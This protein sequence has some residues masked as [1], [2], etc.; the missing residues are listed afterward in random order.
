MNKKTNPAPDGNESQPL[1][2]TEKKPVKRKS[3]KSDDTKAAASKSSAEKASTPK[4]KPAAKKTAKASAKTAPKSAAKVSLVQRIKN[5]IKQGLWW[6]LKTTAKLTL[7][8]SIGLCIYLI[9]LDAKV[10]RKFEGQKWQIPAQIYA[11]PLTLDKNLSITQQQLIEELKALNYR[12]VSVLNGPG[13]F[14]LV[15]NQLSLVRR[16]FGFPRNNQSERWFTINFD[17]QGIT[18]LSDRQTG[19]AVKSITLEPLLIERLLSPHHEDREFMPIEAFPEV[20]KDTLLLVEDRGF[21]HH[22]GVSVTAILRALWQNLKAGR[23][24]QGGSTLTQQLAKNFY[25]NHNR[26]LLRKVNEAFIA[27][28][29]D[30]RYSKDQILEA[31]VNE[32]FLGQSNNRAVHGFGLASRYYFSKPIGELQPHEFAVLMAIIKGPSYYSPHRHPKRTLK[33]RDLVLR[34]MFEHHLLNRAEYKIAIVQPLGVSRKSQFMSV[35]YPAFISQVKRELKQTLSDSEWLSDGIKVFTSLD[36]RLQRATERVITEQLPLIEAQHKIKQ[37]EA[38]SVSVDIAQAAITAMVG[39]RHVNLSGFNRAVDMRR[40]IG[41]LIKP[42]VY[43]TALANPEHYTLATLIEDKPITLLNKSG[44]K[45]QP[46][47]FNHS[48]SGH[49]TLLQALS[50]S[51][52]IPTVNLGMELGLRA[53]TKSLRSLGV[54]RP[55]PQYPSLFLGAMEL[56]P[57]EISQMYATIADRGI[58][59]K[60]AAVKMISTT[61]GEI[62][63]QRA[64]AAK[65]NFAYPSIYLTTKGLM[66]VANTGTARRLKALFPETSFAGKTGTTDA[67]RDSW[68]SGFDEDTL[69]TFWVGKDDY[70]PV[71]LTGSQGALRL[72]GEL[73]R[74]IP[75][76]SLN[77]AVPP[78]VSERYFSPTTGLMY[79]SE[80]VDAVKLPAA[81]G[82]GL[83]VDCI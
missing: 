55:V 76:H 77:V 60:L 35:R 9:Y 2:P 14:L 38:V 3:P 31:Y 69:T 32:V 15:K 68:F 19:Q 17:A 37:I 71:G 49:M 30:F 46:Q 41:S 21:Y 4:A 18:K 47:N 45:W 81:I 79:N 57:L 63:W 7:A 82:A 83:G 20:L 40:N 72:F 26:N 29:L 64:N 11:Q 22:Y 74:L 25:L 36:P 51:K 75:T 27:L 24:V 65:L 62:I 5:K 39:S 58:Y 28:L 43:L 67:L 13:E 33:R 34:L 12:K 44:D 50:R 59:R 61:S 42:A 80:C 78:G 56:S 52:N 70:S 53:V 1:E 66:E 73:H 8:L 10:T 54:R 23:T 6:L 16:A 48:H